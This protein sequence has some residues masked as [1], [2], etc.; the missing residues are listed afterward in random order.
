MYKLK[1]AFFWLLYRPISW[2]KSFRLWYKIIFHAHNKSGIQVRLPFFTKILYN[3]RGFTD[4]Q[5]L[6]FDL[7]HNNYKDYIST[8]E[9]LRLENVNGRFAFFLGEKVMFERMFSKFVNVPHIHCWVK[10]GKF[11]NLDDNKTE[12]SIIEEIKRERS[13]IAKPT[14]SLGGGK[15]I[16]EIAYNDGRFSIDG[17]TYEEKVFELECRKM[18]EYIITKKISSHDYSKSI[19]PDSS[20]T[21]RVI[22][23]MDNKTNEANVVLAFHR[24]GTKKS[25]FVDNISSG[26]IFALVYIKTGM[27]GDAKSIF[28]Y[29]NYNK[30]Y[31]T[32]PDTQALIKGV[33]VPKWQ[34]LIAYLTH[35]HRCFAYYQFFAWDVTL[36]DAGKPWVLE[37]NRGS[38]LS[39]QALC[40]LRQSKLGQWMIQKGLLNN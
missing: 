32:H 38:D 30:V 1:E 19:Y 13:F 26:G 33:S 31:T 24:F 14:R 35:A 25:K 2:Y 6:L 9:R 17:Q 8:W 4:L 40:P 28:D 39:I 27:L 21:I 15:R 10:C 23:T 12:I 11:I 37:I 22:T 20:N 7:K 16:H 5:Y 3:L 36:D 18:E 29:N 34:E